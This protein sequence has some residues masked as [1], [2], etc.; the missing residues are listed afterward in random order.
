MLRFMLFLL[1]GFSLVTPAAEVL[2]EEEE[3]ALG[4][5]VQYI[6]FEPSFVVNYGSSGRMKYLRTDVALRV[7]DPE[8]AAKVS[9]HKPYIQNDLVMLFSA[10]EPEIMNSSAGHE[11]LRQM[12]LTT[13]RN[14]MTR[15]EGEPC[16]DDLYFRNLVVQN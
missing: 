14:L 3:E 16:V 6:E 4:P 15:L 1:L 13:V 11:K 12:A 7:N 10:Q 5:K 9:L 2:A 8:A